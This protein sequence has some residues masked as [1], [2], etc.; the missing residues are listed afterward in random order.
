MLVGSGK[1]SESVTEDE[2]RCR[3]RLAQPETPPRQS[4]VTRPIKAAADPFG[5]ADSFRTVYTIF[6]IGTAIKPIRFETPQ[7][8]S[9][10]LLSLCALGVRTAA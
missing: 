6:A 9:D 2:L 3:L 10:A 7:N 1:R 8:A 4:G 5:R